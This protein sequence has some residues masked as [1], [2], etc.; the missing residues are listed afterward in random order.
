[1]IYLRYIGIV[2]CGIVLTSVFCVFSYN[3]EKKDI[4]RDVDSYNDVLLDIIRSRFILEVND[5]I[6]TNVIGTVSTTQPFPNREVF[7]NFTA[8]HI[9]EISTGI[10]HLC[11]RVDPDYRD[12]YE[13]DMRLQYPEVDPLE[14]VDLDGKG[15]E[16]LSRQGDVIWPSTHVS[17]G[18]ITSTIGVNIYSFAADLVEKMIEKKHPIMSDVFILP[19]LRENP[20]PRTTV[21]ILK[22]IYIDDVI[23]GFTLKFVKM[24]SLIRSEVEISSPESIFDVSSLII[25]KSNID[26]GYDTLF[27][28]K[29]GTEFDD[30][31]IQGTTLEDAR[32]RGKYCSVVNVG[33][34]D[35]EF[36]SILC[37]DE[38][39]SYLSILIPIVI[40]ILC[41]FIA[42]SIIFFF[43][44]D[45]ILKKKIV[46]TRENE[47][48]RKSDFL[49]EM[50]HELRTPLNG[51]MG[52]CE[53]LDHST[54]K[55]ETEDFIYHIK[56]GGKILRN[57]IDNILEFSKVE[58]GKM[59]FRPTCESLKSNIE[60]TCSLVA[61]SYVKRS[62]DI[63]PVSLDLIIDNSTPEDLYA[64]HSRMRQVLTNMTSNSS[65]FTDKGHITVN[66]YTTPIP[67]SHTLPTYM[68]KNDIDIY[69]KKHMLHIDVKDTG[70][71]MSQENVDKL[72]KTFSQVHTDRSV[73]GS[74]LG[75]V[76][77][78]KI[79][80]EMG[81]GISCK[82]VLGQGT[83]FSSRFV[84]I[85][86]SPN[87]IN[88]RKSWDLVEATRRESNESV[89][90]F[91]KPVPIKVDTDLS[92]LIVDDFPL[93]V[94]ML[95]RLMEKNNVST[96]SCNNGK[97]AVDLSVDNKFDI[98][99]IDIHMPIM[100]GVDATKIIR[101]DTE[102]PNRDTNIIFL[103]GSEYTGSLQTDGS[104]R[105]ILKPFNIKVIV[106]ILNEQRENPGSHVRVSRRQ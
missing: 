25:L 42:C 87:S 2:V 98:I 46:V 47:I 27:D 52:M 14:F 88:N 57:L 10:T 11:M 106:D 43:Q 31:V 3:S 73:G 81:G 53:M 93:N 49:S 41:T 70:I 35:T 56:N 33:V 84:I 9:G 97:K 69:K 61:A 8:L 44:R 104:N 64:D 17:L 16:T 50:T 21:L 5:T 18:F 28:F 30:F 7:E 71:G 72:F 29:E 77:C 90:P 51:I 58:A 34:D 24:G 15:I 78:K 38:P 55:K 23:Y 4:H 12:S 59:N 26:D 75:L 66:V 83:T 54:D 68:K 1:M 103:T 86:N 48:N 95:Q 36:F 89:I 60:S 20:R 32:N 100:N 63:E 99:F 40:G 6:L 82:S 91:V 80:E 96:M 37:S 92:V 101:D 105:V 79:C 67:Q 94:K 102:N 13:T 85:S 76:V 45:E 74:G 39:V 65:K 62:P 22:P 19:P